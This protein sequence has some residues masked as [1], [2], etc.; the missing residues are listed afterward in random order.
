MMVALL[1]GPFVLDLYRRIGIRVILALSLISCAAAQQTATSG[2]F[3]L[4]KFAKEIGSE[5]YS[6]EIK[7]DTFTLTSHFLFT[8]RGTRVPLET[9]FVA[10][11]DKL[12][13]LSY[14]ANGQASR[15]SNMDDTLRVA[16]NHI[17]ITRNG[18][19]ETQTPSEPWFI[20]DGYS[21]VAMQE[22]M[23]RWWLMNGRPAEFTVYPAKTTVRIVP[24]GT[25]SVGGLATHGYTVSGLIWGQESLWIDDAQ[26]LIALVSTDA[27]FDHF[28]AMRRP[29]PRRP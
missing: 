18:E 23:M 9:T 14:A 12:A 10:R 1:E 25:L 13:P 4:H 21:P 28:E 20:T 6:I 24:A 17:S 26:N 2:T 19:T 15:Q 22:Q 11:T 8:D 29:I 5:T 3:V 16:S 27:E 7:D